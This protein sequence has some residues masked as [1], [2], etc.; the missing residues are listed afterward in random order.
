MFSGPYDAQGNPLGLEL[1]T[2]NS[3][4]RIDP[5][6]ENPYTDQYIVTFE[7]QFTDRI[8]LSVSGVYKK[9]DNQSGWQDIGGTYADRAPGRP[10][11]RRST[12]SS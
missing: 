1:V 12:C 11:G 2:D 6:F 7:H 4:L 5:G 9:S 10:R 8:G 3:N